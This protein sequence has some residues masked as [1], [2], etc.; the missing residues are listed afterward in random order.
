MNRYLS[1]AFYSGL[2]LI[3]IAPHAMAQKPV[4]KLS[5][6]SLNFG[7]VEA[8]TMSLPQV[9]TLT[10][11]GDAALT[12]TQLGAGRSYQVFNDCP[13]TVNAGDSCNFGGVMQQQP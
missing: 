8:G 7:T 6:T 10:N 4:V 5:P 13:A 11:T 1:R 9:V 12:I 2:L 3:A